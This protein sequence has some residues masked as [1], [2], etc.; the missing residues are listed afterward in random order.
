VGRKGE[1]RLAEF[2]GGWRAVNITGADVGRYIEKR[3]RAGY[4][5]ASVNRELAALKRGFRLAVKNRLVS[6]DH[7][8]T[9][10]C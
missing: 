7:V 3:L 2:F 9:L 1:E 10:R 8:P 5:A 4:A 6:H